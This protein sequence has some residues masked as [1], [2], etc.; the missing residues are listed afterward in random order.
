MIAYGDASSIG[1]GIWFPGEHISYQ[2]AL[3]ENVLKDDIFFFKA[4]TV[5][6]AVH[7]A[8]NFKKTSCLLIY[9]NNTNTFDI[10][11]SLQA[12]LLYNPILI[13]AINVL[14]ADVVDFC[15]FHIFGKDNIIADPLPHFLN[16]LT[17]CLGPN[18]TIHNFTPPQDVL[19]DLKK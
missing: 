3:T 4:L 15:I 12:L 2:C 13:S 10:V 8:C 1:M 6:S 19:G 16:N 9:T 17:L 7:L 11:T 5:C 18:L 14:S